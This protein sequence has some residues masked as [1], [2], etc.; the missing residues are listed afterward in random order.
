MAEKNPGGEEICPLFF[1]EGSEAEI[2]RKPCKGAAFDSSLQ[3]PGGIDG[4]T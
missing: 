1:N 4:P 2:G 3:V